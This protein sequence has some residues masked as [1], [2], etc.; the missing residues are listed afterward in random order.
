M[1]AKTSVG[2]KIYKIFEAQE[3]DD[4]LLAASNDVK[5]FDSSL[6]ILD[7][8]IRKDHDNTIK[9]MI[10]INKTKIAL[11]TNTDIEFYALFFFD[12]IDLIE[13]KIR[14]KQ[15][16]IFENCHS[17]TILCLDLLQ[18]FLFASG[19]CDGTILIWH[20]ETMQ[21]M[22]ELKPFDNHHLGEAFTKSDFFGVSCIKH[23]NQVKNKISLHI[24][25]NLY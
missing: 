7:Q 13:N 23:F 17:D 11:A 6:A 21:K 22:M 24:Y 25:T 2:P 8:F 12:K 1:K 15:L 20:S 19:S 4:F 3:I 14:I 18:G 10:L 5:I 16:E 9:Y